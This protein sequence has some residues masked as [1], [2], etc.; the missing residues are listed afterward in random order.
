MAVTAGIV[1]HK[2]GFGC[3]VVDGSGNAEDHDIHAPANLTRRGERLAWLTEEAQRLIRAAQV[4][5]VRIQKPGAGKFGGASAERHEVDGAVQIGVYRAGAVCDMMNREQVRAALA[6]PRGK[7]A[8]ETLLQ[9]PDVKAR[10]N[11]VRRDQ[12]LLALA[13]Q[14]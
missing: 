11:A 7:G 12:Y 9:R 10:S 5:S 13:A 4:S 8:Y 2:D 1:C 3:T 6:V 14:L